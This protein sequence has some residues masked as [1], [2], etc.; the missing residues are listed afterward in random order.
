MASCP[1]LSAYQQMREDLVASLVREIKKA[2]A[3][4]VAFL[5][6]G[7]LWSTGVNPSLIAKEADLVESL[8]Y[9]NSADVVEERTRRT[10]TYIGDLSHLLIGL[11]AYY[12][13]ANDSKTLQANVRRAHQLNVRQFSFYNYGIMP[14]PNLLWIKDCV[15]AVHKADTL[16]RR[17]LLHFFGEL[18]NRT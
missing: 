17:R 2:T 10:E 7:D 8:A 11:Q 13:C 6:P 5:L 15:E 14:R 4:E 12:P 1:E 16:G 18:F 9:T 3:V